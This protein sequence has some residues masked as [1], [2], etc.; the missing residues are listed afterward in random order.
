MP[1]CRPASY[2]SY[3]IRCCTPRGRN[4]RNWRRRSGRSTRRRRRRR[5]KRRWAPSRLTSW[6]EKY[7]A[8]AKSW[9]AAWDHVVPFFALAERQAFSAEIRRAIYT[10]NAIESLNST[11]RRAVLTARPLP[12]RQGR[13]QAGVPGAAQRRQ[14]LACREGLAF[15]QG[16]TRRSSGVPRAPSSPSASAAASNSWSSSPR[17]SCLGMPPQH[18][19]V[20][21][22]AFPTVFPPALFMFGEPRPWKD[23]GKRYSN[24]SAAAAWGASARSGR[25]FPLG[26]IKNR[27][28]KSSSE[29]VGFHGVG[30]PWCSLVCGP[31]HTEFLTLPSTCQRDL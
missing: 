2:I 17:R 12:Q 28:L 16:G 4:A 10:T 27:E 5:R 15:R 19:G 3:A 11:V 26:R 1:W 24:D 8:I 7:P 31:P 20:I 21:G 22:A 9:R 23:R 13:H 25:Q 30:E 18:R 14:G 29:G 6:N